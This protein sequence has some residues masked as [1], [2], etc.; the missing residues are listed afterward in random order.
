MKTKF[1]LIAALLVVSFVIAV[2]GKEKPTKAGFAIVTAKGSQTFK[3]IYKRE[4]ADTP[5][6]NI[7]NAES[8]VIFSEVVT[9]TTGFILPLNFVA[10]SASE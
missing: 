6:V 3:I 10:L 8:K 9:N 1:H 5:K 4:N 7:Y 2:I